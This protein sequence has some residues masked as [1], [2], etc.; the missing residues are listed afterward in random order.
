VADVRAWAARLTC[1]RQTLRST[2]GGA[3]DDGTW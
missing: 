3:A 2:A 1:R